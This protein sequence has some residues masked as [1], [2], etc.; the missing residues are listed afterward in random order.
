MPVVSDSNILSSLAAADALDLLKQLFRGDKIFIP[1]VVEQELQTGLLYGASYLQR[2][3]DVIH[4]GDIQIL[5]LTESEQTLTTAL[6]RKLHA[7]EKEGIVL[8]QLHN[9]LF[10]SNDQRAIRY[11]QVMGIKNINLEAFLRALWVQRILSQQQVKALLQ[12]IQ[13]VEKMVITQEQLDKIFAPY[14]RK[15]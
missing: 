14:Y 15:R 3:F 6:P 11:C 13:T 9:Y 10:L 8:C 1:Q 5:R 12:T 4:H 2:I 7:G